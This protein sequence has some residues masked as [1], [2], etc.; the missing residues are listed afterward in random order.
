MNPRILIA[1]DDASVRSALNKLMRA[2]GYATILAENGAQALDLLLTQGADLL[3]LD[4]MMP[5][6]DGFQL[7]QRLRE[8]QMT[9]PILIISG[10]MDE[11]D[12]VYALG[13]GADDYIVKPFVPIVLHAKVNAML[14]RS[15]PSPREEMIEYAPFRLCVSS[16]T[17][18]KA[19][20]EI[21]LSEKEYRLMHFLMLHAEKVCLPEQ[22]YRYAWGETLPDRNTVMVHIHK[23]RSK[24]EEDP[25]N[26]IYIKTVRGCGYSFCVPRA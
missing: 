19:G 25:K 16:H 22:L 13:L 8:L 5:V 15:P 11:Y 7:I 1:D 2:N 18:H 9:L 20:R 4:L 17:L 24:I 12:I 23:L 10:E 14:R 26:P 3:L 6:M 21:P